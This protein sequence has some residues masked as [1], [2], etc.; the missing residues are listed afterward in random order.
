VSSLG[1]NNYTALSLAL[2]RGNCALTQ[3]LLEEGALIPTNIW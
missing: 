3:W 2:K 1:G